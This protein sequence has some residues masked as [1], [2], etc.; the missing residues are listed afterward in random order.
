MR[1]MRVLSAGPLISKLRK[2]VLARKRSSV[3][4]R[5][6]YCDGSPVNLSEYGIMEMNWTNRLVL[7]HGYACGKGVLRGC[8]PGAHPV[9]R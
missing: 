9:L 7:D 6:S 8:L 2:R 5:M 1:M 3:S 4:S